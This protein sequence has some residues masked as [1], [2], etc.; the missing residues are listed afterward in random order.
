[1]LIVLA[2]GWCWINL[3]ELIDSDIYLDARRVMEALQSRN[4]S[5]ALSWCSGNKFKLKR[6]K[7]MDL[8]SVDWILVLIF[9]KRFVYSRLAISRD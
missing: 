6:A 7:V 8:F 2:C 4:C 5:E 9:I 1:M 3:Q